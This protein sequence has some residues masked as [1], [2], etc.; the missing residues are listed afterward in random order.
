MVSF[1]GNMKLFICIFFSLVVT[2]QLTGQW[3][4]IDSPINDTWVSHLA[5]TD[6]HIWA[7][8]V[9]DGFWKQNKT[10]GQWE[11]I[12]SLPDTFYTIDVITQS[13]NVF[14]LNFEYELYKSTDLGTSWENI[15][16]Q[17]VHDDFSELFVDG[18]SLFIGGNIGLNT[19]QLYM[20]VDTGR[21]WEPFTF[22]IGNEVIWPSMFARKGNIIFTATDEKIY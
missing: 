8:S 2:Q 15:S 6:D 19:S 3:E 14:A 20:S 1:A 13:E 18:P 11:I 22:N 17:N 7:V 4:L 16:P 9:W 21:T 12:T 10:S 5:V